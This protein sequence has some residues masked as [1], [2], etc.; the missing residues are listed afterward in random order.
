M[1]RRGFWHV[2]SV[3]AHRV[4]SGY[5]VWQWRLREVEYVVER[6]WLHGGEGG[7]ALAKLK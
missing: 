1:A 4:V 7:E 5:L 6:C 3:Y 2:H